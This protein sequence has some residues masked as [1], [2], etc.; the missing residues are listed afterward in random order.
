MP[1]M[2]RV[3]RCIALGASLT[4]IG[5][6]FAPLASA[7]VSFQGKTIN[8]IINSAAGGGTDTIARLVGNA[9]G[10]NLPG[11]PSVI[12]RNIPGGGGIQANNYFYNQVPPDGLTLLSGSRTQI[13]PAKL[14]L[15]AVKYSP[16]EYR[17]IGGTERLGTIIVARKDQVVR[18]TNPAA[19]PLVYGDVDGERSGLVAVMWAKEYL[20]WNVRFILGYSGT[21]TLSLAI[22]R[23]EIDL[24][25]DSSM[26][27]IAPL[28]GDGIDPI[29][30]FGARDD[31]GQRV[32][33]AAL[34]TVPIFDQ[35][36]VPKLSGPALKAYEAW[37]DDQLVDKWL[38]LPP[39]TPDDIVETYRAAYLKAADDPKVVEVNRATYGEHLPSYSG[40]AIDKIVKDLVATDEEDL[41]FL[42]E[43]KKKHGLPVN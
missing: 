13:S 37:R 4:L 16:A 34:P 42:I 40:A 30:Q 25:S 17:F 33:R 26:A 15:A 12:Y 24:V 29:L 7:D 32:A 18:L 21:P 20:G 19:Q 9:L 3:M 38:A 10:K 43:L 39:K 35:T 28:M 27:H 11:E 36:I 31:K 1:S 41:A 8:I 5:L 23:G 14:R 6:R 22:R 2:S